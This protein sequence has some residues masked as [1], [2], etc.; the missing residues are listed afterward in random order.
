MVTEYALRSPRE[1][2]AT[3]FLDDPRAVG[4]SIY[5]VTNERECPIFGVTTK[6]VVAEVSESNSPCTSPI[7]ST[8]PLLNA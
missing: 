2:Q 6:T 1:I 3:H 8:G 5:E 7:T 4:A